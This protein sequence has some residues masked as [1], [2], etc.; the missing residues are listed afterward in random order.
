MTDESVGGQPS[1][2]ATLDELYAVAPGEFV[3]LRDEY[4]GRARAAGDKQAAASIRAA[5]RPT[6]SAW[7]LNLLSREQPA[8]LAELLDI[9]ARLRGDADSTDSPGR[10]GPSEPVDVRQLSARRRELTDALVSAVE[11]LAGDRG[12]ATSADG[13]R[14][15][16]TTLDAALVDAEVAATVRR[17]R[18]QKTTAYAGFGPALAFA[19][20]EPDGPRLVPEQGESACESATEVGEDEA[21]A[22]LAARLARAEEELTSREATRDEA[23]RRRD[24]NQAEVEELTERLRAA[25]QRLAAAERGLRAEDKRHERAETARDRALRAVEQYDESAD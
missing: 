24:A 1:V 11:R 20:A 6:V 15:V 10:S 22:R 19:P 18:L 21:R 17:G 5:R 3:S 14:E 25:E 13:L 23:R 8:E 12:V 7:L 9:G 4:A 2:E 16:R